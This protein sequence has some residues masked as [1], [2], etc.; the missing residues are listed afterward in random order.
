MQVSK[1]V[2]KKVDVTKFTGLKG[3]G[4]EMVVGNHQC[5]AASLNQSKAQFQLE[6]SLAQFS[7]SLLKDIFVL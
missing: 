7:P 1:Q 4:Y 6:L 2:C 5:N 3:S